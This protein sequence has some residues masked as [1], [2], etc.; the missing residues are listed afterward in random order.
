MST[1]SAGAVQTTSSLQ[2]PTSSQDSVHSV[3]K[4]VEFKSGHRI[5]SDCRKIAYNVMQFCEKSKRAMEPIE[6]SYLYTRLQ[7]KQQ[8]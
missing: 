4:T 6:V 8:G 3:R 2:N 1:A 7:L 5:Q